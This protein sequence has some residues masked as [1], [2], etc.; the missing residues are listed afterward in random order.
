MMNT[1][2]KSLASSGDIKDE[3]TGRSLSGRCLADSADNAFDLKS[4]M[5]FEVVRG[6]EDSATLEDL[7][8]K[9]GSDG[10]ENSLMKFKIKFDNPL[11]VSIGSNK[12]KMI[13]TIVDGSFFADEKSGKPIPPGTK[14]EQFLPRMLPGEEFAANMET[15]KETMETTTNSV[16]MA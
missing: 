13:I 7:T 4:F 3:G 10:I 8:F 5:T 1:V 16:A 6:A 2:G 11:K 9:V 15:A 14:M 12:D